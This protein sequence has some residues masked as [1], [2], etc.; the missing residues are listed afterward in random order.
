MSAITPF[1]FESHSVRTV[2]IA[3]EAWFVAADVC[4]ALGFGNSRQAI[5]TH[6]DADDVQLVDTIDSMGRVQQVNA[7][8]ESGMYALTFGSKLPEAKRFKRWVTSEVLPTIRKTGSY[9]MPGQSPA[10]ER[11]AVALLVA[12]ANARMLRLDGSALLG[13]MG[14]VTERLAPELV[15]TL[16]AY[17]INEP[18]GQISMGSSEPTFS[19]TELGKKQGITVSTVVLNKKLEAAGFIERLTR[20]S[21]KGVKSFWSITE[22]GMAYGRNLT[23]PKNEREVAPSWFA[24]R[25]ADLLVEI[26]C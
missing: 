7:V 20:P 19:L 15:G 2:T 23:S 17:A 11:T 8:N 21:T 4:G 14:R 10:T 16:P 22:K 9:T 25:F 18:A 3:G 13:Y 5:S 24:S 26:A 6:V 12:E 1:S